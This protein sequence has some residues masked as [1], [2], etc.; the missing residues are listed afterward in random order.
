MTNYNNPK[1]D[2]DENNVPLTPNEQSYRE[3]YD[4]GRVGNEEV[5]YER[6]RA[7]ENGGAANGLIIGGTLAA[8]LGLG[9]LAY[10]LTNKPADVTPASTTIVNPPAAVVTPKPEKETKVIERTVEKQV[11]GPTKVINVPGPTKVV[12]KQVP[13]ET[14]VIKVP[15]ETKVIEVPKP[16]IVPPADKSS[17]TTKPATTSSPAPSTSSGAAPSITPST[18]P[19]PA[20]STAPDA[21]S[22]SP[23]ASAAPT[24]PSGTAN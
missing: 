10:Y 20:A 18:S 24:T 2:R 15:G 21:T 16:I 14:K 13:G 17:S 9:G 19:S 12:E 7:A 4:R 11:P 23:D 1:G 22:P 5:Q 6:E 8:L 3:G